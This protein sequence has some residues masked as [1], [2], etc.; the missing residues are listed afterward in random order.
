MPGRPF[1]GL[2]EPP[3]YRPGVS[4]ERM[5]VSP[6]ADAASR[7][8]TRQ[9]PE[10]FVVTA[11][12]GP[13]GLREQ[14]AEIDPA[15]TRHGSEDRNVSPLKAFSRSLLDFANGRADLIEFSFVF[16]SN[17]YNECYLCTK[18]PAAVTFSD[19]IAGGAAAAGSNSG[20]AALCSA[21]GF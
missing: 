2:A 12:E 13:G 1:E 15:D 14:C 20:S 8:G 3:D 18:A 17:G 10:P 16:P 7:R 9:C 21:R 5:A 19:R 6:S 11:A 4:L